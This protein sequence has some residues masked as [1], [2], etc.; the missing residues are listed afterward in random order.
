MNAARADNCGAWYVRPGCL[1]RAPSHRGT[2]VKRLLAH[3]ESTQQNTRVVNP[4][5]SDTMVVSIL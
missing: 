5:P 1:N 2:N 3:A 4:I